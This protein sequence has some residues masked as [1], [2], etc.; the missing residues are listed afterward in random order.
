MANLFD[1]VKYILKK[2]GR[3][4]TVKLQKLIY[5]AQAWSLVWD[6]KPLFTNKIK[7]WANGPVIPVLFGAHKGKFEVSKNDFPSGK[8]TQLK[9]EERETINSI[10]EYYGGKSAQW[11][12]DLTRLEDPWKEARKERNTGERCADEITRASMMNYYSGL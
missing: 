10:L 7:A 8:L 6:E 4:S 5:Y 11:L 2:Q 3:I 12:V 1:V 9:K